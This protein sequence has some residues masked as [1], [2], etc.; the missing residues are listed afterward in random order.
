MLV[1]N[2]R[3]V[4]QLGLAIDQQ[5]DLLPFSERCGVVLEEVLEAHRGV[6]PLVPVESDE[7]HHDGPFLDGTH[8]FAPG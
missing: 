2:D 5:L 1:I 7:N 4:P 3:L 6:R 8:L